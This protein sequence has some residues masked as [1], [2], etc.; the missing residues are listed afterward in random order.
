MFYL[1]L[2]LFLAFCWWIG[3]KPQKNTM[4]KIERD[5]FISDVISG[6]KKLK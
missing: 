1:L 6:K 2:F 4:R 3:D 5:I